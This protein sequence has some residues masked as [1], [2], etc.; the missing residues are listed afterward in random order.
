MGRGS[1]HNYRRVTYR[2][3]GQI[4]IVR[5]IESELLIVGEKIGTNIEGGKL[6]EHYGVRM[7]MML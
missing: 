6:E 5:I 3:I 7:G 4:K 1:S 2:G